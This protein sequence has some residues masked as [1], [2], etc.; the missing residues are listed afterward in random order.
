MSAPA[1]G[2]SLGCCRDVIYE[3]WGGRVPAKAFSLPV[4][5]MAPMSLSASYLERASLISVKRGLER[6]LRALGRF[7]VTAVGYEYTVL[8]SFVLFAEGEVVIGT[9][10]VQRLVSGWR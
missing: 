5:M 7:N 4:M 8:G 6:A 9:H 10:L 1:A 2:D 3:G